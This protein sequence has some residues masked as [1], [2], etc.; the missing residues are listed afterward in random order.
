MS[1]LSLMGRFC[2]LATVFSSLVKLNTFF[3]VGAGDSR[4]GSLNVSGLLL[5]RILC[6]SSSII[7]ALACLSFSLAVSYFF[8]SSVHYLR[9][10]SISTFIDYSWVVSVVVASLTASLTAYWL[11]W[12][13]VLTLRV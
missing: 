13:I 6:C 1:I 8:R 7:L 4:F 11:S 5:V 2:G 9:C 10:F 12:I 3:S